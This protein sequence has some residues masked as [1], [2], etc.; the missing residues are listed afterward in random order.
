MGGVEIG[1]A[2]PSAG[3][4]EDP[5]VSTP[6]DFD[7]IFQS[8]SGFVWCVL[9]KLGVASADL[10]DVCQEVF[11]VVHRK[12]VDFDGRTSLRSWIYGICV[13][14]ASTYRRAMRGR[15]ERPAFP[16]PEPH[17]PARQDEDVERHRARECLRLVLDGL[18]DERRAVFVLYEL[19]ELTMKEVAE[20]LGCPLQTAYSRLYTAREAVTLAFRR[21]MNRRGAR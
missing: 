3:S 2:A 5:G 17:A 21:E 4:Y 20:A 18:D 9:A 6:L 14:T 15:K 1:S 7:D 11:V 16:M 10:P 13:R 19:E 8:C 12:L